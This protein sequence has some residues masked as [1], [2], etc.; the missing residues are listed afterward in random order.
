[1][2]GV[3]TASFDDNYGSP[4]LAFYKGEKDRN[5]RVGILRVA[6]L[7]AYT[8]WVEGEGYFVCGSERDKGGKI[9]KKCV[10]CEREGEAK[11]RFGVPIV[12]YGT[13]SSGEIK[14]PL[15][16]EVQVWFF[17]SDKFQQLKSIKMEFGDL[18]TYDLGILCT[19]AKFQR[20][21]ITPKKEALW[22][23]KA[24]IKAEIEE[25]AEKVWD[26]MPRVIGKKRDASEWAAHYGSAVPDDDDDDDGDSSLPASSDDAVNIDDLL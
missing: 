21:N 19:E 26:V 2:S 3:H 4:D 16:W 8:H 7:M 13:K 10:C 20:L 5:D 24:E 22:S 1:M 14:K 17:S 25:E 12:K 15:Q 23:A 11:P 9:T 18:T 6:P